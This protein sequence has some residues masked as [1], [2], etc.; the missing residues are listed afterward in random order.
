[1]KI[2]MG[3]VSNS[4]SSSFIVALKPSTDS[5][6]SSNEQL[7]NT[8]VKM[9]NGNQREGLTSETVESYRRRLTLELRDV[10]K[11]Q[12]T[13]EKRLATLQKLA[14]GDKQ[15]AKVVDVVVTA[16]KEHQGQRTGRYGN[17]RYLLGPMEGTI[18]H[19]IK[20]YQ[21]N[22]Q[23]YEE[24]IAEIGLKLSKVAGLARDQQLLSWTEDW[25][26]IGGLAELV[27]VME[28]EDRLIVVE[29]ISG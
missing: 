21:S 12:K 6:V 27:Q 29:R 19:S 20:I 24:M 11:N 4:S 5:A 17:Y 10:L 3:F 28:E 9:G 25:H 14:N 16:L 13:V 2:R 8:F 26:S 7:F 18:Q 22:L 1:M 15:L 23:H